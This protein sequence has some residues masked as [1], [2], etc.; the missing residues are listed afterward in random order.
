MVIVK[1]KPTFDEYKKIFSRL[2]AKRNDVMVSS[3]IGIDVG[4]GIADNDL[5]V[6]THSDPILGAVK[7]AGYLV[8]H[9]ACND[10]ATAGVE[11]RWLVPTLIFPDD[12]SEEIFDMVTQQIDQA[13]KELNVSIIGGHTGFTHGINRPI[14]VATAIGIGKRDKVLISA[15]AKVGDD[16]YITKGAAIEG[17]SIVAEDFEEIAKKKGVSKEVLEKAKENFNKVSVVK[18]ALALA[19]LVNSMH[20]A[21]TGGV[22]EGLMELAYSSK[23]VIEVWEDY[24]PLSEEAKVLAKALEYDPLWMITAGTLIFTAP[25][26]KENEIKKVLTDIGIP[27][28]KIGRIVGEGEAKVIIHRSNGRSEI[29]DKPD[30]NKEELTRLWSVYVW[31]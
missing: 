17:T 18:E 1:N 24:I 31:K 22:A 27:F 13:S 16:V 7:H 10:V 12:T 19:P 21:T 23:K 2:G 25:K 20:D 15:K 9:V 6:V 11:P 5:V 30:P 28:A 29:V 8:V 14:V 3:D 26:E 4:I